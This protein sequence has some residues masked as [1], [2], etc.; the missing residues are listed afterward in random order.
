[1][2][3]TGNKYTVPN[4]SLVEYVTNPVSG[5]KYGSYNGRKTYC[6]PGWNGLRGNQITWYENAVEELGCETTLVCHIPFLEYC[7]AYEQYQ[8]AVNKNDSAKIAACAP[9]GH[10]T[11]GEPICGSIENLGMFDA[12]LRHNSTK[13]VITGHDHLNDFSLLYQGVRLTY[14]VKCGEGSYWKNDGT[15][16]GV[17]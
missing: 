13:N 8:D 11:M 7:K 15:T 1:M 4:D 5:V 3:D 16:C 9:I 6:D 14:S 17:W 2:M 12:I 10:C